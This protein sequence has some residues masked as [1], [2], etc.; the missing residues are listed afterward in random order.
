MSNSFG[1]LFRIT[2]FGESHGKGLGVII[3]GCPA[4][5]EITAE[6]IQIELDRRKPGQSHITTA[7]KEKDQVEILSG[8]YDGKT[9]GTSIGLVIYNEDAK[10]KSYDNLKEL[11]RPSHADYTYQAKYGFR[12][13]RGGGRA[14]NREATARVAAGAVAKKL[15]R[16]L[17]GIETL[18]WVE[19]IHGIKSG[20]ALEEVTFEA[21]EANIVR[22]PDPAKA[23]EMI[24]CVEEAKHQG[25]SVGGVIRFRVDN[26][27]PGLGSPVFDKITATMAHGLM[28][29]PATRSV[30]F[31][32]GREASLLKGSEHNDEFVPKP[33]M[34]HSQVGTLTN[35]A[36]GVLGGMTS[37]E[38]IH[39]EVSF[40]PTATIFKDQK[41]VTHQGEEILFQ[42]KGRHDPCVLPRAVPNVEAMLNLV[43]ADELLLLATNSLDRL[44]KSF[45]T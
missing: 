18:A 13:H 16:E 25:D 41:T 35:K 34:P 31:G 17:A 12:D 36:G 9:L 20:L 3:D 24:A 5:L 27:P 1:T 29:I 33:G 32:M 38:P 39:G 23:E 4:G 14:S 30:S 6:E 21:I 45:A 8:I 15:I 26:A 2:T 19:E 10:S 43:L 7:R 28:S 22:C 11:F 42:A 40:K 37:G 44:K